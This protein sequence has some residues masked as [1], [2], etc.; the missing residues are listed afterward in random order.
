MVDYQALPSVVIVSL[1]VGRIMSQLGWHQD[2][3]EHGAY[4]IP[5]VVG[6]WS[7][8]GWQWDLGDL[9]HGSRL[10]VGGVCPRV[11]VYMTQGVQ[12]L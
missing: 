8:D 10:H 11:A 7:W 6:F 5:L 2:P 9:R 3:G 12:C 1:L 4:A